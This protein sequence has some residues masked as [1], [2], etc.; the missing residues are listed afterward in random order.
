[1]SSFISTLT[2]P[3]MLDEFNLK[4][5]GLLSLTQAGTEESS[6]AEFRDS[7]AAGLVRLKV[8]TLGF[9]EFDKL[10]ERRRRTDP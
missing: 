7:G 4:G 10:S 1:M 6:S 8:N 3:V 9:F 2:S 5:G